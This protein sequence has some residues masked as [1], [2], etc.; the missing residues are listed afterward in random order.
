MNFLVN[1]SR[2][3]PQNKPPPPAPENFFNQMQPDFNHRKKHPFPPCPHP[4]ERVGWWGFGA[5][6]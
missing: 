1:E 6:G 5:G 2:F 4:S 3:R